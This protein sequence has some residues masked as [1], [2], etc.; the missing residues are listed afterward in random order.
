MRLGARTALLL[1]VVLGISAACSTIPDEDLDCEEALAHA[2]ECCERIDVL[3]FNC[4]STS[5]CSTRSPDLRGQTAACLRSSSCESLRSS[6]TCDRLRQA[7]LVP[8]L[9]GTS[10]VFDKVCQ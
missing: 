2:T 8:S 10:S 4:D 3:R 9:G 7:S 1:L 6:G 5:S